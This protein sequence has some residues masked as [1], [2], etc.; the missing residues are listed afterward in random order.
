MSAFPKESLHREGISDWNKQLPIGSTC[1]QVQVPGGIE[2]GLA[3][4]N[5][6]TP[7]FSCPSVLVVPITVDPILVL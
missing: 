7:I 6:P 3:C 4:G 2:T 1:V 5:Q